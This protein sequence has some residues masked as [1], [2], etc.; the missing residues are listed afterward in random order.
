SD[1]VLG[2]YKPS[3]TPWSMARMPWARGTRSGLAVA[4]AE[5]G[6]AFKFSETPSDVPVARRDW[7]FLPE[8]EVVVID[9][10]RTGGE[11]RRMYLRFRTPATL[12]MTRPGA[13]AGALAIARGR[14][15]GSALAIHAV[16]IRPR[17][18]PT[19]APVP[20]NDQCTGSFGSCRAAR[21]AVG[22]YAL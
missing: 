1:V 16:D 12:S 13:G 9:R 21:F 11:R 17:A 8:G 10:A 22:E 18:V 2:D 5:V 7:V 19:V 6:G 4:R 14:V 15:G 3:Q 20:A